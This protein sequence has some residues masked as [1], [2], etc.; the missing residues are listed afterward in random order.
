MAEPPPEPA[1]KAKPA[2]STPTPVAPAPAVR[3][4]PNDPWV[5]VFSRGKQILGH[6]AGGIITNLR[7][8]Y[9]DKPRKVLAKLED[10]AEQRHPAEWINAFLLRVDDGGRLSGCVIGMTA[11]P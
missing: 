5:E 9:D 2:P 8:L 11:P 7:K 1:V 4:D 6:N 3:K 10:A